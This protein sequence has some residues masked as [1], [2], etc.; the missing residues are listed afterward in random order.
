MVRSRGHWLG[1]L[2]GIGA[3]L[4]PKCP[5]CLAGYLS[6][7]GLGVGAATVIA[8]LLRPFGLSIAAISLFVMLW[9]IARR[10]AAG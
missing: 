2:S 6:F 5:M 4:V 1:L 3:V 8:P 9:R 7:V 10:R